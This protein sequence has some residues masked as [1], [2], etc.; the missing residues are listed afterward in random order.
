[1]RALIVQNNRDLGDVWKR[2]LERL[3]V[4]VT[5]VQT[6]WRATE[7]IE[8][9]PFDV[10]VM[11]LV[12]DD[13]SGL[14]LSDLVQFRQPDANIIFV[15][16]TTFLSDGSI[17]HHCANAR[18]F[19]PSGTPPNDLAT[20]VHHYGMATPAHAAQQSLALG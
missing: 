13:V 2:H 14:A 8:N 6:G 16:N 18:A 3:D 4:A 15:T 11:D 12:V 10:I 20:I 7:M 19:V 9:H 5:L 1:M 17:F